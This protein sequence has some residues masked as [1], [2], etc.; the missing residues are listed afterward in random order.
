LILLG[1]IKKMEESKYWVEECQKLEEKMKNSDCSDFLQWVF[2]IDAMFHTPPETI[3]HT[4]QASPY[5]IFW[6]KALK[7]DT[8]GKP[9]P[10]YLYP[11]SSGNLLW[12]AYSLLQLVNFAPELSIRNLKKVYEFGG[13]YGSFCRML[14]RMSFKG[15]YII[16]DFPIFSKLQALFFKNIGFIDEKISLVTNWDNKIGEG[17]DL[18]IA[19]W[20]I[21][22]SPI[23]LR[24]KIFSTVKSKYILITYK[25]EYEG[26][27]NIAYFKKFK[28][29]RPNY[30]WLEY[31][32]AHL[33]HDYYLLGKKNERME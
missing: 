27:D 22:E 3:L 1:E 14:Y 2:I 11:E 21:S 6:K 26:I 31:G 13:G 18:F 33:P 17:A 5:W 29:D 25:E 23:K 15:E 12:H 20:S 7:E 9:T 24:D 8:F 32:I 10:Y 19:L 30:V 28:E 16:Y 4:L